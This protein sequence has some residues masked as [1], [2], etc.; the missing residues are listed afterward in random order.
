MFLKVFRSSIIDGR[1][2]PVKDILDMWRRKHNNGNPFQVFD[3]QVGCEA[4]RLATS[5]LIPYAMLLNCGRWSKWALPIAPARISAGLG[6]NLVAEWLRPWSALRGRDGPVGNAVG[7]A[8]HVFS[9]DVLLDAA[10]L[11]RLA[12]ARA[13]IDSEQTTAMIGRLQGIRDNMM[14]SQARD[15]RAVFCMDYLIRCL[16]L[17]G[18]LSSTGKF[19]RAVEYAIGVVP[20]QSVRSYYEWMLQHRDFVPSSSTLYRHRL[21]LSCAYYR[22]CAA[23]VSSQMQKLGGVVQ[24]A[25]VDTSPQG[26]YDWVGSGF[27]TV[28]ISE[29]VEL[30][31][32][33][34]AMIRNC[35]AAQE[36][37]PEIVQRLS[38]CFEFKRYPPVGIGSGRASLAAKA[39]ALCHATR[40]M[41]D[42]W[43]SVASLLNGVF[44]WTGDL[45]TESHFP[46]FK[47]H[48]GSLFGAWIYESDDAAD[49][50][51]FDNVAA[52]ENIAFDFRAEADILAQECLLYLIYIHI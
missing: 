18:M 36:T 35:E 37:D 30:M 19:R 6:L 14:V 7:D 44:S 3:D 9:P 4:V 13:P 29:L 17:S 51:E 24:W 26:G 10:D 16:M 39:H 20:D 5:V 8:Q 23:A 2:T 48:L 41:T 12:L 27:V 52:E 33:A 1:G 45:G 43:R 21:T 22:Y 28:A 38:Y 40:L 49:S 15:A 31:T 11:L 50:E 25:T 34:N 42:S 32:H 47:S 46:C